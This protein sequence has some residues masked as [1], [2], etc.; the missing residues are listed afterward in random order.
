MLPFFRDHRV[1]I[2]AS[3]DG[4]QSLHNANR[5]RPG[6]D[7]HQLTLVGIQRAREALGFDKV[8][9]LMTATRVSLEYPRAIVDEYVTHG[10]PSI[11]LQALSPYG[12]ALKT[13]ISRP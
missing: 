13:A 4:P 3:L 10:F 9:A 8:D 12:F 1:A 5:S 2:S 11:F 7:S 6:N